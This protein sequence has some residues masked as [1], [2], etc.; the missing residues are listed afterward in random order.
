MSASERTAAAEQPRAVDRLK[1]AQRRRAVALALATDMLRE[2]PQ[3]AVVNTSGRTTA[4]P[5][6][7]DVVRLAV[8]IL[9]GEE[10][11][12]AR[13]AVWHVGPVATSTPAPPD[14]GVVQ[15]ARRRVVD[16][17]QA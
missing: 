9:R 16:N 10:R 11:R 6:T 17:P 14:P 7:D 1:P 15:G 5:A 3:P 8:F 4:A 12:G 2:R 13:Q